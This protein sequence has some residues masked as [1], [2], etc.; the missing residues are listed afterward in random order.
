MLDLLGSYRYD[1][2]VRDFGQFLTCHHLLGPF[3][4]LFSGF[5]HLRLLYQISAL[6]QGSLVLGVWREPKDDR[7]QDSPE[8]AS[9]FNY[10]VAGPIYV[11]IFRLKIYTDCWRRRRC[12]SRGHMRICCKLL[13]LIILYD[14]G[15]D[16]APSSP[17]GGRNV[18]L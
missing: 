8:T 18:D 15:A 10:E 2:Y 9:K 17:E 6:N 14:Q 1:K 5:W 3:R 4:T 12:G 7:L 11:G 13:H 16:E